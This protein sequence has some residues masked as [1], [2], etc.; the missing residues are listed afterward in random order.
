MLTDLR[1]VRQTIRI[2]IRQIGKGL[3]DPFHP[4][5]QA[6]S[7]A[8]GQRIIQRGIQ[9]I[10]AFPEVGHS[11][12][13]A[14]RLPGVACRSMGTVIKAIHRKQVRIPGDAH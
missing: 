12:L 11:I 6:V 4:I 14:V 13:V 5:D 1:S 9:P 10:Q 2:G 8:V 7:V 3:I